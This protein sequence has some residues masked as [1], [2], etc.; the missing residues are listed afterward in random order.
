MVL[1]KAINSTNK[2][3]PTAVDQSAK[4]DAIEAAT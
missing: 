1:C 3:G 4:K 2:D